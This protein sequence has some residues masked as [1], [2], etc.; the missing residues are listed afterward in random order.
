LLC[1]GNTG[2]NEIRATSIKANK[3]GI[4]ILVGNI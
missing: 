3:T 4:D 2:T 1:G